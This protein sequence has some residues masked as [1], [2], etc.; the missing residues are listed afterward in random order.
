M[1]KGEEFIKQVET[2]LNNRIGKII[3]VSVLKNNLSK[4]NKNAASLTKEDGKV[5][6]ENI[7]KAVSLFETKDESKLIKADLEKLLA[8][9]E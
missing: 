7:V 5:L 6:A 8:M 3:A 2:I 9:L 1:N 4:L